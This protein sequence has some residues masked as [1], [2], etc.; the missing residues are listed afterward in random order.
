M[1]YY[2]TCIPLYYIKNLSKTYLKN[3]IKKN[4]VLA[5][6]QLIGCNSQVQIINVSQKKR[7]LMVCN[8]SY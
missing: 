5:L 7:D 1:M 3:S 4:E 2:K 8:V 6:Q